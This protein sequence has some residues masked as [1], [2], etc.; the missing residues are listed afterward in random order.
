ML[1]PTAQSLA[2]SF[3][4][5]SVFQYGNYPFKAATATTLSMVNPS[6]ASST[7]PAMVQVL[8]NMAPLASMAV[9]TAP[10]PT[11]RQVER[12]ESVGNLPL[13]PYS[14]MVANWYVT[15]PPL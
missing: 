5:H 8:A 14:S 9:L 12:E 6:V 3:T 2:S 13:L 10:M 4:G 1:T 15:F 7:V 11:I